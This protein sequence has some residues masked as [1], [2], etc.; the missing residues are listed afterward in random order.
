MS[1]R[2][3]MM[4]HALGVHRYGARW[5]KPYRNHYAAG[6]DSVAVWRELVA[7]GLAGAFAHQDDVTDEDPVFYVTDA[8]RAAAL[9]GLTFERKYGY[10]TPTNGGAL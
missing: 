9:A 7:E 6:G 1:D 10:G 3:A 5:S 8:G 4:R 2:Y